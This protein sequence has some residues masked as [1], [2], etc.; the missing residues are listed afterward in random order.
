MTTIVVAS[1]I[2]WLYLIDLGLMY[3]NSLVFHS[4]LFKPLEMSCV[5]GRL[6]V[7]RDLLISGLAEVSSRVQSLL[8]RSCSDLFV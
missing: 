1:F 3:A 7:Q 4:L 5:Y 6:R 2:M 8:V